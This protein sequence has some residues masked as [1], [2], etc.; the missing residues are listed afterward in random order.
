MTK[1]NLKELAKLWLSKIPSKTKQEVYINSQKRVNRESLTESIKEQNIKRRSQAKRVIS[2]LVDA[3]DWQFIDI[4]GFHNIPL[5]Q[6]TYDIHDSSIGVIIPAIK[7]DID[8]I[9]KAMDVN[10][11]YVAMETICEDETGRW[12]AMIFEPVFMDSINEE[13]KK[14][15]YILHLTPASNL[16]SIQ[17]NGFI[18]KEKDSGL[19]NPPRLYF[20]VQNTPYSEMREPIIGMIQTDDTKTKET[21]YVMIYVSVKKLFKTVPDIM[22]YEDPRT[23]YGVYTDCAIPADCIVL[24]TQ[25]FDI[26]TTTKIDIQKLWSSTKMIMNEHYFKQ[27]VWPV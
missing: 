2:E 4:N 12:Y 22:F 15:D 11:Y 9:K 7:V 13:I 19:K 24:A 10:D 16:E 1:N 17:L 14:Y 3:Q 27:D 6:V 8:I 18:P 26:L 23:E 5:L 25:S 20:F 21:S